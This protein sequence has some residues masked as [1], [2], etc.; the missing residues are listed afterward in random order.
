[1]LSDPVLSDNRLAG[2]GLSDNRLAGPVL[3]GPGRWRCLDDGGA[4]VMAA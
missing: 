2:P 3:A 4:F 1:V